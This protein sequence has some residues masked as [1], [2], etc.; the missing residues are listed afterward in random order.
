VGPGVSYRNISSCLYD[1]ELSV[2]QDVKRYKNMTSLNHGLDDTL[3]LYNY[4]LCHSCNL[5]INNSFVRP[6]EMKFG[7]RKSGILRNI[8]VHN[9][10]K[11]ESFAFRSSNV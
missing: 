7:L 11:T 5:H 1:I 9:M 6:F 10:Q 2:S 8:K 3:P 4:M